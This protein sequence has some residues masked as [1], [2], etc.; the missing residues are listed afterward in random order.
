MYGSVRT[1]ASNI[2]IPGL[3]WTVSLSCILRN[4]GPHTDG[5]SL[6]GAI[7]QPMGWRERFKRHPVGSNIWPILRAGRAKLRSL[8]RKTGVGFFHPTPAEMEIFLAKE[9]GY[10]HLRTLDSSTER[11]LP[12]RTIRE[13]RRL[14][15]IELI[16][17]YFEHG[18]LLEV[19][20]ATGDRMHMY[21]QRGWTYLQGIEFSEQAAVKAQQRGFSVACEPVEIALDKLSDGSFDTVVSSMV[22]EHLYNPFSVVQAIARI[23]KPGGEF[24]FSTVTLDSLDARMFGSY[25]SGYDFPRHMVYFRMTDIR[26]MLATDFDLTDCFHQNAP[27]DFLRPATWRRSEGRISDRLIASLAKSSARLWVGDLLA[28]MGQTSRVSFR[29]RKK[30]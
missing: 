19:G 11:N 7:A 23:L 9:M 13:C 8:H 22:L 29:C 4:Y 15:G 1:V 16:P 6:N 14:A 3:P 25:W 28:R 26:D 24:I 27:V 30:Q 20:C 21:R 5:P 18:R 2:R 12:S 17:Y 10:T